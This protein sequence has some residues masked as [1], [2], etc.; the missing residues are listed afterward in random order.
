MENL[1]ISR[2]VIKTRFIN[3]FGNK[4]IVSNTGKIFSISRK[5]N[6]SGRFIKHSVNHNG[7]ARVTLSNNGIKKNI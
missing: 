2:G 7:Y 1:K 6:W 4:Y 3:G 5:G